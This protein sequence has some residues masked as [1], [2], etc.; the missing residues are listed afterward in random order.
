ME[1]A[2]PTGTRVVIF[3]DDPQRMAYGYVRFFGKTKFADGDWVGI[4]LDIAG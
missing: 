3:K 1:E 4:E 2:V